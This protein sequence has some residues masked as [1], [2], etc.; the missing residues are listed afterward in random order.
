MSEQNLQVYDD[1]AIRHEAALAGFTRIHESK[2]PR[3]SKAVIKTD[4]VSRLIIIALAIV[5]SAAVIVSSSRTVDEFGGGL[6][7][8]IAF[9]MIEGGIVVYAL[10]RARRTANK[11]RLQKTLKWATAGLVLTFVIGVGANIDDALTKKGVVLPSAVSTIINL[12]VAISAP[13]LAFISSDVLAI[14]LMATEIRRREAEAIYD[15]QC[16]GWQDNLNR[17]WASKQRDWGVQIKV[18]ATDGRTDTKQ[19]QLSALSAADGQ[20]TDTDGQ[21]HGYGQGY[22]KRTD[23]RTRVE[24]YLNTNPDAISLTARE[25]AKIIGVGK[26]TVS[27]VIKD[28]KDA[29]T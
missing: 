20:R 13:T 3:P 27:E 7:G 23:A 5:M 21:S 15:E 25:L 28:M 19:G 24:E 26:T 14:E 8:F 11:E 9:I 1:F 2:Y 18:E 22:T 6:L 16:K 12:L 10:F 17:S 29:S 4:V